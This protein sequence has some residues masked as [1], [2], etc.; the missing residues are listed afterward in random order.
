[1]KKIIL[2]TVFVL[3]LVGVNAL[4][5][6]QPGGGGGGIGGGGAPPGGVGAG[7]DNGVIVLLLLVTGYSNYRLRRRYA[8]PKRSEFGNKIIINHVLVER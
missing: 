5:F 8:S 1:M 7:I 2:K 4:V 6:A 3:M